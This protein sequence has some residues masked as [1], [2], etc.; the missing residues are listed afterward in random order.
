[1]VS[2][3]RGDQAGVHHAPTATACRMITRCDMPSGTTRMGKMVG[4]QGIVRQ[5]RLSPMKHLRFEL[6]ATG[7][8]AAV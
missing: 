8:E 3:Q 4:H 6:Y 2:T 1:M 5:R 7:A